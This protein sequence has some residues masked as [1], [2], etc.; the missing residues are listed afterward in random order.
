MEHLPRFAAG[1]EPV[2]S[3]IARESKD[4]GESCGTPAQVATVGL[5]IIM[6]V[7]NEVATIDE[8]VARVRQVAD[9]CRW[10]WELLIVDDGS[11]DGT[12]D[13][14]RP[15]ADLPG[16]R[17]LTHPANRG[18]GAA[19]RTALEVASRELT[20]IQDA[21]LEYDPRQIDELVR[22]MDRGKVDVV[23]G[24]RVLGARAGIAESRWNIFALGV[25]VLNLAVR[26]LYGWRV[27]DEA[28]CYK[29]FRTADLHRMQLTCEGFE[30]C[31]EVTAKAARLGLSMVEIPISYHPR[32]TE[33]GKKIRFRDA[34]CAIQTLWKFRRWQPQQPPATT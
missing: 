29:L 23:Y 31:P 10:D 4:K 27:T 34:V 26:L 16:V 2:R 14:I 18:K 24:S 32:S 19:I 6:P 9:D 30:F 17:V 15:F 11:S 20:V 33:E 5:S 25:N 13:R 3:A 12:A 8:V 1:E 21:D 7:Y 22:A 28:T